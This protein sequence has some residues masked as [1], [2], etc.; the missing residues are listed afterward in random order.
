MSTSPLPQDQ[1][2]HRHIGPN[3]Q[4]IRE[5]LAL[6]GVGSL[7]ELIG[8]TVPDSIRLSSPLSMDPPKSETG[9][10]DGLKTTVAKNKIFTSYIGLG[11]YNCITPTVILRNILENPG[12]YTSYTPYQAEVAQGR[13]EA[14]LTYQTMIMDLTKMAVAN[15][16]LLDE[17]TAAAEAMIMLYGIVHRSAARA[18]SNKFFVSETCFPQTIDVIKTR[19]EAL[20]FEIIVGTCDKV[21][22]DESFFGAIVQYP[23]QDGMVHDYSRMIADAHAKGVLVVVAA[24]LMSLVHLTPPGEFGADVVVGS[25]QRF[26]IPM[27]FGGPHAGYFATKSEYIRFMP[28]RIIGVSVDAQ[29]KPAF[30]MTLQTREQHIKREKA[31]SNICT[32][33]AL[34]AVMA[35]M[36]AVYHGPA[37]ITR[38]ANNI[39]SAAS[40]LNTALK[41]L[42]YEQQNT[43][44]F[45]TLKIKVEN[46]GKIRSL[47]EAA[48]MNFRFI[49]DTTIGISV[50][51]TT[52]E[53]DVLRMASLFADAKGVYFPTP[54]SMFEQSAEYP[55]ELS[56]AG[57]ILTHPIFNMNHC[58]TDMLRYLKRLENKDVSLAHSMIALG[59]CTMKLN[60]TTEMIPITWDGIANIHPFAPVNQARGYME[61][62]SDLE[63]DL[64]MLTGFTKVSFQPNSGAQGEF[65]GLMVIRAYHHAR[66]DHHRDV[67]LIP[68]SAHGTNPASAVMAGSKVVI[69]ACDELGNI[70]V[71]DLKAKAAQHKNELN[72]LMVTYP[73]THGV[74]EEAITE[75]CGII[76][77]NGGQVYMDGANMNAQVGLTSPAEIGADVCHINLH[78]TFAIPHGGGGP[79]MGPICVAAHLAPF[80]PSHPLIN[81][82]AGTAIHAVAAAPFGSGSILP[83]SYAYIKLLGAEGL[84]ESTKAAILNANYL[85]ARLEGEYKILYVGKQGRVAHEFILDLRP[86]KDAHI[87]AEDVAKRLMDYGFH[88][89]TVSF[90]VPGTLMIEPTESEAKGELDRFAEAMLAIRKEIDE[91]ASGAV[92]AHDNVLKNAPHTAQEI[93]RDDWPHSYTREKAAYPVPSLRRNKFWPAVGRIN[94]SYGDRN[95]MCSCPPIEDYM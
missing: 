1:F 88:A 46:A 65:T 84:T 12:W 63:K 22:I 78:K 64:C 35:G 44:F 11:Y 53:H 47:A 49:D 48:E 31:T 73:S 34:L 21:S 77:D 29:N 59:S 69:V 50:D 79:G 30:R 24:D 91:V 54:D 38:I 42:G 52:T 32:A 6:L 41:M 72:S 28:G 25:S 51:E 70:D 83:I 16:S 95:V 40:A 58:E 61:L 92:D 27:G 8:Q 80:L 4:E 15:A 89:P 13:L 93:A 94:N 67:V 45:D 20:G 62:I 37:G 18:G 75:I 74:F 7:D 90:P 85:K 66:G 86:F 71:A 57:A 14:M 82:D 87:E 55:A 39:H 3:E 9:F 68:A 10:L 36:F 76:H 2:V 60:A 56:R 43:V 81:T 26:G 5:M 19:A 33:Q 23:S 17:A